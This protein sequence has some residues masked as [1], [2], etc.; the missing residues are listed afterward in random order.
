MQED[1]VILQ[2]KTREPKPIGKG[3]VTVEKTATILYKEIKHSK[4]KIVF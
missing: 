2:W 4:V 1:G 3:K